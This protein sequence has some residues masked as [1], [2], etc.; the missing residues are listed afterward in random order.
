MRWLPIEHVPH[1]RQPRDILVAALPCARNRNP[2]DREEVDNEISYDKDREE[3]GDEEDN[4]K[5]R[6]KVLSSKD[7]CWDKFG[8][9]HNDCEQE[10]DRIATRRS[11][12]IEA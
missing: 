2:E 12:R 6:G 3:G 10:S 4:K 1:A 8:K 11:D 9:E 7:V 5:Y